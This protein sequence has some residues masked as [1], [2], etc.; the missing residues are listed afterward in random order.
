NTAVRMT[1]F[2]LVVINLSP[3]P[4]SSV[5]A[6]VYSPSKARAGADTASALR[7]P[8]QRLIA[9]LAVIRPVRPLEDRRPHAVPS[10]AFRAAPE[11][12]YAVQ[13]TVIAL[14]TPAGIPDARQERAERC[15]VGGRLDA[16]A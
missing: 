12:A 15:G 13:P 4:Q 1:D 8:A 5:S 14:I 6:E 7:R 3:R 16:R 11:P 9:P 2:G 10:A